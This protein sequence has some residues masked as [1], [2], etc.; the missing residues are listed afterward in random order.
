MG[1][2]LFSVY[3]L[4]MDGSF[5]PAWIHVCFNWNQVLA[6]VNLV[7]GNM[8]TP[9]LKH[10]DET[11]PTMG[12]IACDPPSES[13]DG[14]TL[15]PLASPKQHLIPAPYAVTPHMP[16]KKNQPRTVAGSRGSGPDKRPS[17][18]SLSPSLAAGKEVSPGQL[19][20]QGG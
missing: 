2:V 16:P 18:S 13:S 9:A 8:K 3:L 14:I 1:A 11:N 4:S 15:H 5:M 19:I 20:Q 10:E 12:K 7:T 17:S 6:F